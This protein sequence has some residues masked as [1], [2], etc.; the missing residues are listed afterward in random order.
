MKFMVYIPG[1]QA[2]KYLLKLW[3]AMVRQLFEVRY[4]VGCMME[5]NIL[6]MYTWFLRNLL[7]LV[8]CLTFLLPVLHDR[9][10][11]NSGTRTQI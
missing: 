6:F 9:D 7:N 8:A 2:K 4:V 5:L 11:F 3:A 1:S 10:V